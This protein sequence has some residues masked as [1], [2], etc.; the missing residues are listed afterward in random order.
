[1]AGAGAQGQWGDAPYLLVGGGRGP[2]EHAHHLAWF[3]LTSACLSQG[4]QGVV[5]HAPKT[6]VPLGVHCKNVELGVLFHSTPRRAY[7][8]EPVPGCGCGS[9]C[10]CSDPDLEARPS[11]A[12]A[13]TKRSGK[14]ERDG[15]RQ[16]STSLLYVPLPVP[17]RLDSEPYS[18]PDAGSPD[19]R[20]LPYMHILKEFPRPA[21][22]E[23]LLK[24][25][26]TE[27]Q[28]A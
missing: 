21:G 20:F 28:F 25:N 4:A 16:R 11:V 17:F 13:S 22:V 8:V 7:Y 19:L 5:R 1:G 2:C 27:A 3:L 12:T 14:E 18:N 9:G 24:S 10:R 6:G 15:P 26:V 23:S